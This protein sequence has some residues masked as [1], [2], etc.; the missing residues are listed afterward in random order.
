MFYHYPSPRRKA[1][2]PKSKKQTTSYENNKQYSTH[3]ILYQ[4][5]SNSVNKKWGCTKFFIHSSVFPQRKRNCTELIKL[6]CW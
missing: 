2:P 6:T 3:L 5:D 4:I 1:K